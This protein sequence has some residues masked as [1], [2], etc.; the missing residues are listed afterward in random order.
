MNFRR[1][2]NSGTP[3]ALAA[4]FFVLSI[5]FRLAGAASEVAL[6]GAACYVAAAYALAL[7]G[8]W[9]RRNGRRAEVKVEERT[10][11]PPNRKR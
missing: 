1:P 10:K 5:A 11:K 6:L 3:L 2:S 9:Q 7:A 4:G 8:E